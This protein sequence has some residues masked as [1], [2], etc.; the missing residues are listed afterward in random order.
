MRADNLPREFGA[1]QARHSDIRQENVQFAGMLSGKFQRFGGSLRFEDAISGGAKN[2]DDGLA[3]RGLVVSD[4]N[5]C[6]AARISSRFRGFRDASSRRRRIEGGKIQLKACAVPWLR[7]HVDV[8]AALLDDPV[9][10]GEAQACTFAVSLGCEEGLENLRASLL[11]DAIPVSAISSTTQFSGRALES[12]EESGR[13]AA[14]RVAI[15]RRPPPGIASRA[16]MAKLA[17]T[18]SSCEGSERIQDC[19]AS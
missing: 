14:L 15:V 3:K 8:A 5:G 19:R 12:E 11:V 4:E 9:H 1:A 10:G 16:L 6:A 13:L 2:L 18:C 7:I 17:T